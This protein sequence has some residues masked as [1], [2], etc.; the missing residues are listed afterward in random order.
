MLAGLA[1]ER[2]PAGFAPLP[3]FWSEQYGVRMQSFGM[4]HLGLADARVLAG[5]LS[6]D[7]AVGFHRDGALVG[8]V[9]FG[10]GRRMLEFRSAVVE[11]M[12]PNLEPAAS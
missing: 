4:P 10:M 7:A 5:E 3:T 9:L 11:A 12:T 6:G 1:G 8:V 2:A